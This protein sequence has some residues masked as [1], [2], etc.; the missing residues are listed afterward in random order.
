MF[1]Q[2][3]I[4]TIHVI[5]HAVGEWQLNYSNS[6]VIYFQFSQVILMKICENK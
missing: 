2:D 5:I 4:V 1:I 6:L 3:R